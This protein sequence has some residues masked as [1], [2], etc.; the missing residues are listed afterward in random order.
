MNGTLLFGRFALRKRQAAKG[1]I[2]ILILLVL[3]GLVVIF[4][5]LFT[6]STRVRAAPILQEA[7]WLV[8]DQ[9]VSTAR[10]GENV[11]ADLVIKATEEYV[12]SIVVK[13]RKDIA[14]WF[15]SNYHISTIPVNLKG[16]QEQEMKITFMPDEA[17]KGSLRGYFVE[18]EFQVTRTTWVMENSYPPRL[19]VRTA[20]LESVLAL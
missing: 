19:R 15:D 6:A 20:E 11:E 16:G 12:G 3:V 4:G 1:Q 8:D 2:L 13:I 14:L 7:F 10:I 18:I 5:L 17:S 9:R